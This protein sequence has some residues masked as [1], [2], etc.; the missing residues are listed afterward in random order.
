M[1]KIISNN[2]SKT[3]LIQ[4]MMMYQIQLTPKKI[5]NSSKMI[6]LKDYQRLID[7]RKKEP[8]IKFKLKIN[9]N[10]LIIVIIIVRI[11]KN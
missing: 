7:K 8:K 9:N 4:I 11:I 6:N 2:N 3:F 10:N 5:P 1:I